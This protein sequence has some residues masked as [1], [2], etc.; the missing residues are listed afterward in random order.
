MFIGF[1]NMP[2]VKAEALINSE[3]NLYQS[4][5]N[6]CYGDVI[7]DHLVDVGDA[8][9]ILQQIV[10]LTQFGNDQLQAANV[11]GSIDANGNQNVDVGDALLVL[12][13][14]VG[15]INVF[16]AESQSPKLTNLDLSGII[17]TLIV[18]GSACTFDL[19]QLCLIG[20]DQ[21]D[22]PFNIS[23]LPVTWKVVSGDGCSIINGS[24]LI[25]ISSGSAVITATINGVTSNSI[26]SSVS[27]ELQTP[28]AYPAVGA[29]AAGT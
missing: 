22:K 24:D 7:Q 16:P 15:L 13:H 6:N 12:K 23:G 25:A 26:L 9:L 19:N 14:I 2:F 10:G 1:G 11:D 3:F 17:P 5:D 18:G 27:I 8:I 21:F 29:V 28:I 4:S 20:K